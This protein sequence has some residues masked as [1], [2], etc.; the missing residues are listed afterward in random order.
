M[1]MARCRRAGAAR[2]SVPPHV[3]GSAPRRGAAAELQ[4]SGTR[5]RPPRRVAAQA[6][7]RHRPWSP[8]TPGR[9]S[10]S[11][12]GTCTWAGPA[13]SLGAVAAPYLRRARK[14]TPSTQ[15]RVIS[16]RADAQG[17][18]FRR[19]SHP[20]GRAVPLKNRWLAALRRLGP[21][22]DTVPQGRATT[23]QP[24]RRPCRGRTQLLSATMPIGSQRLLHR[25]CRRVGS[26]LSVH[27]SN[28]CPRW[29]LAAC[30]TGSTMLRSAGR[31]V[32]RLGGDVSRE[33][34]VALV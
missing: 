11:A 32:L 31:H 15:A 7:R 24:T 34:E 13:C 30:S 3:R 21:P 10:S 20:A 27:Q 2:T 14:T 33:A 1:A 28:I 17:L 9:R 8:M 5:R 4:S 25:C 19:R 12:A 23:G 16:T 18:G 26:G 29:S 22:A 6:S